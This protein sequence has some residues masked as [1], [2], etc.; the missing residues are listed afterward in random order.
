M[1]FNHTV[2]D[3]PS[4]LLFLKT[5]A[6]FSRRVDKL[7]PNITCVHL[8]NLFNHE[9]LPPSFF[10]SMSPLSLISN[11]RYPH[12]HLLSQNSLL[13]SCSTSMLTSCRPLLLI[14]SWAMVLIANLTVYLFHSRICK[15]E[16]FSTNLLTTSLLHFPSFAWGIAFATLLIPSL[17]L[18]HISTLVPISI[19]LV[20]TPFLFVYSWQVL[21]FLSSYFSPKL[22]HLIFGIHFQQPIFLPPVLTHLTLHSPHS[23]PLLPSTLTHLTINAYFQPL[24]SLPNSLTH[25][26][27]PVNYNEKINAPPPLVVKYGWENP[28]HYHLLPLL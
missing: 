16:N 17:L 10:L 4:S 5:G 14:S 25:L 24:P 26:F 21:I 11:N 3:L 28:C 8:G 9:V 27:L 2:D 19:C 1:H 13:V 7:P 6:A 12:F 22:L 18:S 20:C 15:L 23:M